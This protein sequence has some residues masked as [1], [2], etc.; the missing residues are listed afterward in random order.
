MPELDTQRLP[1]LGTR[2]K[3]GMYYFAS[4]VGDQLLSYIRDTKMRKHAWENLK[5]IFATSTMTNKL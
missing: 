2:G 4:C 3:Q 1:D 5:R